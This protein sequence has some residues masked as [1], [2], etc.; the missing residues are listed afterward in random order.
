[1]DLVEFLVKKGANPNQVTFRDKQSYFTP[2]LMAIEQ[3]NKETV[4][5]LLDLGADINQVAIP[6]A[7]H[8]RHTPVSYAIFKGDSE[9]V[10]LLL[11]RGA[12]P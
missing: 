1:M 3:Y 5:I 12:K 2:L 4:K 11:S 9:M 7:H 8:G 6:W 10:A